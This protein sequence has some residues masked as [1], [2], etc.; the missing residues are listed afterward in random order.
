LEPWLVRERDWRKF[1]SYSTA[2][3]DK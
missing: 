2:S 3:I 1:V